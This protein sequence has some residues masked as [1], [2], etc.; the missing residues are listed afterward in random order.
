MERRWEGTPNN[1]V[2]RTQGVS[3]CFFVPFR[4]LT[5]G[6]AR[7]KCIACER[8]ASVRV[9]GRFATP[10]G[11]TIACIFSCRYH[12]WHEQLTIVKR[13]MNEPAVRNRRGDLPSLQ[14]E[15]QAHSWIGDKM[16]T[17][18]DHRCGTVFTLNNGNSIRHLY[19]QD[20]YLRWV[21]TFC[22]V[23]KKGYRF[24]INRNRDTALAENGV[25]CTM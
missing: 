21:E 22:P 8:E 17:I 13:R 2:S 18:C 6:D 20:S 7:M 19:E 4:T 16:L 24:F 5:I 9:S 12:W 3:L 25:T 14:R 1:L 15:I 10:N 11:E 23:C